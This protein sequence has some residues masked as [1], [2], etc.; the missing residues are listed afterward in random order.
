MVLIYAWRRRGKSVAGRSV[1]DKK[2][3]GRRV[4][5]KGDRGVV[6]R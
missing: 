2:S 3:C 5:V 6:A 4:S 1:A